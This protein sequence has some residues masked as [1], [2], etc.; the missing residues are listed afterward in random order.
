MH[1]IHNKMHKVT[2]AQQARSGAVLAVSV[3]GRAQWCVC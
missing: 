3:R 1:P 2:V